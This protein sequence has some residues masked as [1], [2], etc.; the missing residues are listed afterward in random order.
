M[1][2]SNIINR[3]AELKDGV[4]GT[5]T[6][7]GKGECLVN[8]KMTKL[9]F[10]GLMMSFFILAGCDSDVKCTKTQRLATGSSECGGWGENSVSAVY[11][12]EDNTE[13]TIVCEK[14]LTNTSC[15][16]ITHS[17]INQ[18]NPIEY[19]KNIQK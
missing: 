4:P 15:D 8:Y 9:M 1:S 19:K 12:C 5:I 3:F 2:M 13:V 7:S 14:G 11:V 18:C 17:K 16:W 10:A 6:I